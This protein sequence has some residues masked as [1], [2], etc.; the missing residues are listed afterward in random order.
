MLQRLVLTDLWS[1]DG[2]RTGHLALSYVMLSCVFA[3]LPNLA[4]IH[5]KI[6]VANTIGVQI[7]VSRGNLW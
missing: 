7:T 1:S 6:M 2:K 3:T 5:V 4:D